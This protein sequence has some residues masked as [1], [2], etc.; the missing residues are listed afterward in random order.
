MLRHKAYGE[1]VMA[2][3]SMASNQWWGMRDGVRTRFGTFVT[4]R[5]GMFVALPLSEV[6]IG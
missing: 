3:E 6:T 5:G 4:R 2:S 1:L